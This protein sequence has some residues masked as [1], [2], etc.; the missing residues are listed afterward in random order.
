MSHKNE[1]PPQP[2]C[3]KALSN[4]SDFFRSRTSEPCVLI[5]PHKHKHMCHGSLQ[6][7]FLLESD[8]KRKNWQRMRVACQAVVVVVG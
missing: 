6:E 3:V 5:A 4:S 8:L 7:V 1:E 2:P